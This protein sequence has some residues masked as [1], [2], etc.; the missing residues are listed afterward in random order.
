[1]DECTVVMHRDAQLGS[2]VTQEFSIVHS[3]A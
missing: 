3:E 2:L 1:M